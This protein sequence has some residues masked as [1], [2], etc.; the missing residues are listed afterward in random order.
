MN[1][2]PEPSHE[3][4]PFDITI[5]GSPTDEETAAVVALLYSFAQENKARRAQE[6]REEKQPIWS[7]ERRLRVT[8]KLSAYYSEHLGRLGLFRR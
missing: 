4:S 5:K 2:T 6:A 7:P 3:F 1:I 8:R